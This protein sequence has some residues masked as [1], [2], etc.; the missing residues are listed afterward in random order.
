[1]RVTCTAH[2]ILIHV[3]ILYFAKNQIYEAP[4]YAIFSSITSF[5]PSLV[6]TFFLASRSHISLVY[7]V[8]LMPETKFHT[9]TQLTGHQGLI[10]RAENKSNMSMFLS[11]KDVKKI[12]LA[13]RMVRIT[14]W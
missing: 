7:I 3:I 14:E 2:L 6:E 12:L 10:K 8:P 5:R 11:H 9:H 13:L 1:M 4:L